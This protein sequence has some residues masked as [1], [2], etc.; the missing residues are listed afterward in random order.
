MHR[1]PPGRTERDGRAQRRDGRRQE[2]AF[3]HGILDRTFSHPSH[4]AT[5]PE[6]CSGFP[7]MADLRWLLQHHSVTKRWR[8][9]TVWLHVLT[10][11]S[12]MAQAMAL[13]VLISVGYAA[14]NLPDRSAAISMA[15]VLDGRLL[16]PMA[17]ASAFTGIMLA[18]ATPWG[19]FRNWWVLIK[20]VIT[21][22]QLY[23]GIFL[24]SPTLTNSLTAGPSRVQIVGTA[25]MASAIGHPMPLLSLALL[26]IGLIRRPRWINDRTIRTALP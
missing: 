17:D 24:L 2:K 25:F 3:S 10:S 7:P 22:V 20:F 8:Q 26:A 11:V 13:G 6:F 14:D 4:L 15:Y 5:N 9:L 1:S 16:G 19:F 18:A 21:L 12:W 23:V